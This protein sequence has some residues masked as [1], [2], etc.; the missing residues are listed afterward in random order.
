MQSEAGA[1]FYS[2]ELDQI[3]WLPRGPSER[4]AAIWKNLRTR[5]LQTK[6]AQNPGEEVPGR[7]LW[8][9]ASYFAGTQAPNVWPWALLRS[10]KRESVRSFRMALRWLTP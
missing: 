8:V 4:M 1:P 3:G 6:A 2:V 7:L 9:Q 10:S 5:P